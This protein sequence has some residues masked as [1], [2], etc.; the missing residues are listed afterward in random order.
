M[1]W[2]Y[3]KHTENEE[4][5]RCKDIIPRYRALETIYHQA[6]GT[7]YIQN[8][9]KNVHLI[10]TNVTKNIYTITIKVESLTIT[11]VYKLPGVTWPASVLPVHKHPAVYIGDFNIHS[12]EW[13][14]NTDEAS[15][16]L[17]SWAQNN[18]VL[19][20]VKKLILDA[21]QS[22]TFRCVP[23]NITPISVFSV[24]KNKISR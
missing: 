21:K 24:D 5:M 12:T 18:I 7:M 23:D 20:C 16:E 4:Q 3:R 15:I 11:N 6:Y 13:S 9:S 8:F 10:S 2:L 22:G 17:T 19:F 14:Y 1:F